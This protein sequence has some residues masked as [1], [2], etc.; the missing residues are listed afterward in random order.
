MPPNTSIFK[1]ILL[2]GLLLLLYLP[3]IQTKFKLI[4]FYKLAGDEVVKNDT[5]LNS[6]TYFSGVYQKRKDDN[7]NSNFGF[8][9]LLIK[10]SN[11]I[12]FT[13]F[14]K[15]NAIDVVVGKGG[16]L[17]EQKYITSYNGKDFIGADSIHLN[18]NKLKIISD[19][20]LRLNKQFI[21]VIAPN[22]VYYYSDFLYNSDLATNAHTNYK[23][24]TEGLKN[25]KLAYIDF[26]DWF[27]KIKDKIKYPLMTKH[28]NHWSMYGSCIAADSII[29]YIEV[30]K[31]MK[32]PNLYISN[33]SIE[34]PKNE[35]KD[36][37]YGINLLFKLNSFDLAYPK[38]SIQHRTGEIK[39][40]LSAWLDT[41][42]G[43]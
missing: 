19:K 37:E 9:S 35:D 11:Q 17:F 26:N 7:L 29:K 30:T 3:L 38:T 27:C 8:R 33:I 42:G 6:T 24:I 12:N 15:A 25:N 39:P 5:I 41:T 2:I 36:I 23:Y 1:R 14:K 28:G 22:K 31:K 40:K 4:H 43:K 32:M 21:I 18:L 13:L 20:L 34:Q 10:I 16:Y